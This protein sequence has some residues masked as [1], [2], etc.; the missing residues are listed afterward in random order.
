[1]KKTPLIHTKDPIARVQLGPSVWVN[2]PPKHG[3]IR[4]LIP[5][6]KMFVAVYRHDDSFDGAKNVPDKCHTRCEPA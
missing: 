4:P 3:P 5:T 2:I 1:M 6:A